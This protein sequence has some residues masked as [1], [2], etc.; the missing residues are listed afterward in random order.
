MA[1]VLAAVVE[2]MQLMDQ[3]MAPRRLQLAEEERCVLVHPETR[4][5]TI[6]SHDSNRRR[7]ERG[8]TQG[9]LRRS[10]SRR[11]GLS[12]KGVSGRRKRERGRGAKEEECMLGGQIRGI[13]RGGGSGVLGGQGASRCQYLGVPTSSLSSVQKSAK[14]AHTF[15]TFRC[16]FIRTIPLC[17]SNKHVHAIKI[18]SGASLASSVHVSAQ[19]LQAAPVLTIESRH[20]SPPIPSH[21]RSP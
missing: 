14:A 19:C 3:G 13:G 4:T 20:H 7:E 11:R 9:G 21:P 2:T 10:I 6:L 12:S 16:E 15:C 5:C 18:L 17:R 8:E 1:V